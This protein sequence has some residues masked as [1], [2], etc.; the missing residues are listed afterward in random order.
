[1]KRLWGA[2]LGTREGE[3]LDVL[4]AL[5]D[6]YESEHDLMKPPGPTTR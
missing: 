2:R 5:V 6:A 3:R 1:M 4:A